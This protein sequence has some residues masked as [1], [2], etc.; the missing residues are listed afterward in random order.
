MR[1]TLRQ[2]TMFGIVGVAATVTH[3]LVA[4]SSHEVL[5]LSL[6]LAN[7]VGY[8]SAVGLS[9][10]GH[11]LLTFRVRL[12]RRIFRR[13]IIVSIAT[14][15]A[16]EALL[17]GLES[18]LNLRHRVSLAVVVLTI[19]II[20]FLLNKLWVYRHPEERNDPHP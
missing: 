7:L 20:S 18:G 8:V 13:F 4:L 1:E 10:F 9:C 11:S 12:S 2:L 3:Y 17:A 16:S 15:L 14:F 6:Y 19:P 5:G